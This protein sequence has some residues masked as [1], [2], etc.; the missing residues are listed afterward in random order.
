MPFFEYLSVASLSA[1]LGG[2][3]KNWALRLWVRFTNGEVEKQLPLI[4]GA[5]DFIIAKYYPDLD[6]KKIEQAI[7]L[8]IATVAD[9]KLNTGDLD[10][11]FKFVM[12]TNFDG[13]KLIATKPEEVSLPAKELAEQSI[14]D[15]LKG[16]AFD[17][18]RK[19]F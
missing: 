12:G 17:Q 16:F 10:R 11:I 2:W 18:L 15:V 8:V 13:T 3:L 6:E 14:Q 1:L 9:G 7:K 19:R 4:Y 5:V